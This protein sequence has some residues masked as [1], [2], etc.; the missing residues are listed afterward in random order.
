M[1]QLPP[2]FREAARA[3]RPALWQPA[4]RK[5]EE[6]LLAAM[7]LR[8][9]ACGHELE[10]LRTLHT[11]TQLQL[12]EAL[13]RLDERPDANGGATSNDAIA[14]AEGNVR[15]DLDEQLS[16]CRDALQEKEKELSK[17]KAL[18]AEMQQRLAQ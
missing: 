17:Y 1:F 4:A 11:D 18:T 14:E 8:L 7:Q 15:A 16:A 2:G 9:S 5:G 3:A 10:D 13:A 12:R 6:G